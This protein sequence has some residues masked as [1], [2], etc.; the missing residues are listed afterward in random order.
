MGRTQGVLAPWAVPC[1]Q[2]W[3]CLRVSL[4][5]GTAPRIRSKG[6]QP[7]DLLTHRDDC[8]GY[9]SHN[10]NKRT[11]WEEGFSGLPVSEN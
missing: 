10:S 6:D 7:S 1:P 8:V 4:P 5:A 9:F 2:L 11:Q 3:S